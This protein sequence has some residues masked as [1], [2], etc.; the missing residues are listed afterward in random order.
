MTRIPRQTRKIGLRILPTH[1]R[2]F[3]GKSEKARTAAK[4]STEY[5][6]STVGLSAPFPKSGATVTV[7]GT[8]AHLGI[9]KNGPIVR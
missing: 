9:A 5:T 4:K 2:I 1:V 6:A 3:P 7:K 8:V